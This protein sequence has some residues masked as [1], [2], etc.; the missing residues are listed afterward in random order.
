MSKK[1][2]QTRQAP[3]PTPAP[4]SVSAVSRWA[5]IWLVGITVLLYVRAT[6]YPMVFDDITY[7]QQNPLFVDPQSYSFPFHYQEFLN[8]PMQIGLDPELAMNF[9]L[10]PVAYATLHLNY[11]LDDFNPRWYRLFNVAI[12][13][14]NACLVYSILLTLIKVSGNSLSQASRTRIALL[15]ATLFA[16]HPLAIESVTYIVQ[17]FTSLGAF[18]FL[19]TLLLQIHAWGEPDRH[20]RRWLKGSALGVLLLGMFTKEC[21]ITAP[22]MLVIIDIFVCRTN[23]RHAISRNRALLACLP[24]IPLHVLLISW[25]QNSSALDLS[26]ALNM[27]NQ[28]AAPYAHG[29][30]ILTQVTVL[31]HYLRLILWPSDL[32]LDPEWPLHQSIFAM[33]VIFSGLILLTLLGFAGRILWRSRAD[34]R[35]T[36]TGVFT[37][38]FFITIIPSS[39]LV[40]LPDLVAEHRSYLPSLGIIIALSCLLDQAFTRFADLPRLRL[41]APAFTAMAA[42]IL[43]ALTLQQ[44]TLWGSEIS[45]WEDVT[46]K[47]PGRARAWNNLGAAYTKAGRLEDAIPAYSKAI[48][49]LPMYEIPY[50]NLM[51]CHN[52]RHEFLATLQVRDKLAQASAKAMDN[53]HTLYMEALA[54]FGLG[55]MNEAAALLSTIVQAKPDFRQ[56]LILLGSSLQQSNHHA[57]AL[58]YLELATQI[59]APN[60]A[61]KEMM[62]FSRSQLALVGTAE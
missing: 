30:Y 28:Q 50:L 16:A 46:V 32:T 22:V 48:E 11:L 25:V 5:I 18:F 53:V 21:T 4:A 10:R 27:T 6:D 55:Q 14:A 13:A 52:Q 49:L 3:V 37:L 38:W 19:L 59:E 24:L 36:L 2:H 41:L 12:H 35:W 20:I 57:K 51:I 29:D 33:P 60:D 40:P 43:G 58:H 45:L 7:L 42:L 31:V 34:L 17:R 8:R 23:W 39:G 1:R 54:R 44:N 15:A 47:S 56:A 61:L 62:E 26:H 9:A